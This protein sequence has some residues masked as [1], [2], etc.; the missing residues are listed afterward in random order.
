MSALEEL[1]FMESSLIIES[2]FNN[3]KDIML[4][5]NQAN[6]E[7]LKVNSVAIDQYGY[8]NHELINMKIFDLRKNNSKNLVEKQMLEAVDPGINFEAIHYRKDGSFFPVE[9][10]SINVGDNENKLLLSTV[11]DI[12]VRKLKENVKR[13]KLAEKLEENDL[14]LEK[15]LNSLPIG[16]SL[17]NNREY[18]FVNEM[19]AKMNGF[20]NSN[21]IVGKQVRDVNNELYYEEVDNIVSE[22]TEDEEN[23]FARI[24]KRTD[25]NNIEKYFECI[26]QELI[27]KNETVIMGTMMEIT[28]KVKFQELKLKMLEDKILLE[29]TLEYDKLK[30]DFLSN[31]SHEL[32]TPLNILISSIQVINIYIKN[33][34]F[35]EGKKIRGYLKTM[36][37]NCYRLLRLINNFLDITKIDAGYYKLNLKNHNI[38][39]IIE[40]IT[41]S[42]ANYLKDK[43]V[44]LVFDTEVEEKIISC[45][46]EKIERII[47]NLLSNALKFTDHG[48]KIEVNIYDRKENLVLSIK[49]SGCGM[50]QDKLNTIFD[51]FTQV[52]NSFTVGKEG[53][54]IGLSLVKNLVEMH[55]GKIEVKSEIGVGTE[56]LI[57]L[58]VRNIE[59]YY[60]PN[61]GITKQ[62]NNRVDSHIEKLNIEFSDIYYL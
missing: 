15:L 19:F 50:P 31:V 26:T 48:G 49:D 28:N 11:R 62:F 54:G 43:N 17:S 33:D 42:V 25:E 53:T 24:T 13:N 60:Q 58:P 27:L 40:E 14:E 20:N 16:I 34:E 6:G 8:S 57:T 35:K 1:K 41:M 2:I 44:E 56:F 47:L 23:I 5:V 39:F 32:R 61:L 51:R 52:N 45:D 18:F 36:R 22:T 29:R 21:E 37:Q 59:D 4:L 3:S 38:I 7:V 10:N 12:T 46:D 30:T 55:D 9:V